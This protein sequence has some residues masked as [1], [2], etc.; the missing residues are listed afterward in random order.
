[1]VHT[2]THTHRLVE[3]YGNK[4]EQSIDVSSKAEGGD[5]DGGVVTSELTGGAKINRILHKWFPI[6]LDKVHYYGRGHT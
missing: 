4:F 1:M 5:D 6:E 2:H 3:K